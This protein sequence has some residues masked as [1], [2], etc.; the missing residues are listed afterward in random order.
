MPTLLQTHQK[1]LN[2]E[3]LHPEPQSVL[4]EQGEIANSLM[5]VHKGRLAIEIHQNGHAARTIAE[6]G[7]GAVLGEMALLGEGE[8]RHGARVRVLD[9]GTEILRF[10]RDA[11]HSA[12]IFDAELAAEMLLVSSE[13]CRGSNQM[14]NLL[15]D[16]IDATA[17]GDAS[18]LADI[19]T[20]LRNGPDSMGEAAAQ[21]EQ[22]LTLAAQP[23]PES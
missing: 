4:I 3:R 19:C 11:L 6:V 7:A 12:I 23:R 1:L 18:A 21:L 5:L 10:S 13:R 17:R 2:P 16:G 20:T 14:I 8:P 22:L 15:L 9:A